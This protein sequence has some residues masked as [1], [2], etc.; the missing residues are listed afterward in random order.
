MRNLPPPWSAAVSAKDVDGDNRMFA[1]LNR[2]ENNGLKLKGQNISF[3]V[4]VVSLGPIF[5][6]PLHLS[7]KTS[8]FLTST[9]VF[10]L[11][12]W[13]FKPGI[14]MRKNYVYAEK[15]LIISKLSPQN[16]NTQMANP[17]KMSHLQKARLALT[18]SNK[19]R[20]IVICDLQFAVL[21]PELFFRTTHL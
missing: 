9:W 20:E 6:S 18:V 21:F 13:H 14:E 11:C 17:H 7:Y 8:S 4:D 15:D 16:S 10:F 3:T 1:Q 2:R 12:V 5:P 19:L